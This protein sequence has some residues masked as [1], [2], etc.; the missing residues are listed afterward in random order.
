MPPESE[1]KVWFWRYLLPAYEQ[2]EFCQHM[3]VVETLHR[4]DELAQ[5]LQ[6]I[7]APAGTGVE[8]KL[9]SPQNPVTPGR[10]KVIPMGQ[11]RDV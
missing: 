10:V 11:K 6:F 1:K 5:H 4:P 8:V 7:P 2:P 9:C 3:E